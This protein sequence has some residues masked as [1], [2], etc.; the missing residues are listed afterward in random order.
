MISKN[1]ITMIALGVIAVL[2][3]S[4]FSVFAQN[5]NDPTP[6]TPAAPGYGWYGMMG[7]GGFDMM[8]FGMMWDVDA[9]SMFSAAAAALGIDQQALI[10]ELQSGKTITQIAQEKGVDPATVTTALQNTMAD[11]LKALVDAGVLTQAQADA[12]LS[13][14]QDHW[15]DMPMFAGQGFGM[16]HGGAWGGTYHHGMMGFGF[17][18]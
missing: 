6:P 17:D 1:K 11:H 7:G 14:M 12:R 13:L 9:S 15:D 3:F 10:A 16:M 5:G 8:G 4:A 18:D 2:A